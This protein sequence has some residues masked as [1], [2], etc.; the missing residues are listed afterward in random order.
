MIR[1]NKLALFILIASFT[2]SVVTAQSHN[3]N[4]TDKSAIDNH[5]Y[6]ESMRV[7]LNTPASQVIYYE[8]KDLHRVAAWKAR[9]ERHEVGLER[10]KED[11][12]SLMP[13]ERGLQYIRRKEG[14]ENFT[15][16]NT[17]K[18]LADGRCGNP[19]LEDEP[20]P[21]APIAAAPPPPAA[22]ADHSPPPPPFRT[23]SFPAPHVGCVVTGNRHEGF[24]GLA[25]N[26]QGG[27]SGNGEVG[28]EDGFPAIHLPEDLP[29]GPY[30]IVFEVE[31]PGGV[32]EC[33][34]EFYIE[35]YPAM[36]FS[37]I[38]EPGRH[39]WQKIPCIWVWTAGLKHGWKSVRIISERAACAAAPFIAVHLI[40]EEAVKHSALAAGS[41]WLGFPLP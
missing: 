25:V 38:P 36:E 30:K 8:P 27:F 1:F 16:L 18:C 4:P 33:E 7:C 2:A 5:K 21:K 11:H 15:D 29:P 26:G 37:I 23:V 6:F 35:D 19:P 31:G 12:C 32:R 28:T 14:T 13:T 34:R 41:T 39:G 22:P 9:Y 40:A 20:V 3:W 10:L 17:G 24:R